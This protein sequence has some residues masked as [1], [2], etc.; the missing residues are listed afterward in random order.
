MS[1]KGG[2][3][4][5]FRV[6]K[7]FNYVKELAQE[8]PVPSLLEVEISLI[9]FDPEQPRK[10]INETSLKE[11]ATSIKEKG[12]IEPVIVRTDGKKY[13][14]ISGERRVRAAKLAGLKKVPVVIK[15]G[16][17]PRQI[18]EIQLI[19]NLQREDI[20]PIERA[21]AIRDYLSSVVK[22][23]DLPR[24][25]A[26]M[27]FA[28]E[29]VPKE[30]TDTVSVLLK[31]L[32]KSLKTLRRWVSLLN[33]PDEIKEKLKDPNSP[34]TSRHIEE[35]TKLKDIDLMKEVIKLIEED[36]LS[37]T[38]TKELIKEIKK[39]KTQ[40]IGYKSFLNY[41][42]KVDSYLDSLPKR[43][44]KRPQKDELKRN[45]YSLKEKIGKILSE[46]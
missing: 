39:D 3:P 40:K 45:L 2:L 37:S 29:R 44:L 28:P 1:R 24:V 23:E 27:E 41:I 33:L 46:I 5:N 6:R 25:L 7:N 16:L 43:R 42:N 34:L 30:V 10:I 12:I 13:I 18:R 36:H 38:Q 9:E 17:S 32:G 19:E 11:L 21:E 4:D 31:N 15:D 22:E 8:K 14:L 20:T 26:D 35:L